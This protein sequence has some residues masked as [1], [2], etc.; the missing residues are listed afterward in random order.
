MK[1]KIK[2]IVIYVLAVL[3]LA[4]FFVFI[5]NTKGQDSI[6]I[7]STKSFSV[8]VLPD[9]QFYSESYQ[10]I[11]CE[12]VDWIIKN[13]DRLNIAFVSQLGDIVNVSKDINQW[14]RASDCIG[15]L[16]GV[17]PYGIVSGNHD[18]DEKKAEG[19]IFST[20][21]KYFPS[22]RFNNYSWYKGNF[23]NNRNNYEVIN[24]N[25]FSLLFLN[26]EIEPREEVLKW[27]NDVMSKNKDKYTI[28]TTHKY[29]QVGSEDRDKSLAY[30][31]NGNTAEDIWNKLIKNNCNISMVW[32]GH[33]H[34]ENIIQNKNICGDDVYEIL[35]DYQARDMG[36]NGWLRVYVFTP[37]LNK[38]KVYTYSPY[39]DKLEKDQNS[40]FELPLYKVRK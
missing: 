29:L 13:K 2:K 21:D 17:L 3:F 27:A 8:V 16:D 38:I 37:E 40:D 6:K 26:L 18:I 20:Y 19:L 31:K 25:G 35:Q 14:E 36:G 15:R 30:R 24:K 39:L 33:Y 22:S 23:D 1:N 4:V 7:D 10:K 28:L 34:G 5:L 12:Q 11:L 32:S 9:I